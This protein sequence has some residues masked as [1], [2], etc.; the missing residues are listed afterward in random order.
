MGEIKVEKMSEEEA[1]NR[2][3]NNWPIWEKE[4]S[5]FDW[6]YDA[7]EQCYILEGRVRVEPKGGGEIVEFAAGDFVTFPEGLDCVW[8]ISENVRKHYN[9]G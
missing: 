3:I 9:F 8:D 2:G 1:K 7:R 6:H 4:V 5:R